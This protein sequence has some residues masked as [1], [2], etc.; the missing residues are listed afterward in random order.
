M[1][2][3]VEMPG[4]QVMENHKVTGVLITTGYSVVVQGILSANEPREIR[5]FH[6]GRQATRAKVQQAVQIAAERDEV[7]RHS[8]CQEIVRK[9]STLLLP[10]AE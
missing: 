2:A 7:K 8:N 9:L 1:P 4:T 5:W 10:S 6:A 3:Y